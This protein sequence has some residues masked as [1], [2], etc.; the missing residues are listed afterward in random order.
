MA[1]ITVDKEL[2]RKSKIGVS[3]KEND[4]YIVPLNKLVL[5]IC[6]ALGTAQFRPHSSL[7]VLEVAQLCL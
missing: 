1:D 4:G 7:L 5:L 2:N 3:V 6:G